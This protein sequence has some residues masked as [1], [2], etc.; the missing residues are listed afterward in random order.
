MIVLDKTNIIPYL[1]EHY[2]A[3]GASGSVSVSEIGDNEE[4]SK[5]LINYI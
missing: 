2:P 4:D 1:R 5:G 3:L